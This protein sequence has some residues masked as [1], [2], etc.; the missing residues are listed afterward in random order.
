MNLARFG[1][2]STVASPPLLRSKFYHAAALAGMS[3]CCRCYRLMN[4]K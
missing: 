1:Y 4:I 2:R 3:L